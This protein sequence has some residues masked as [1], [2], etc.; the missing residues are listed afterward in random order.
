QLVLDMALNSPGRIMN[1]LRT[2]GEMGY[3]I[4]NYEKLDTDTA[5]FSFIQSN[6][7]D[8]FGAKFIKKYL[9]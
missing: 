4:M 3:R 6:C 8:H 7:T 9:V 2:F 5:R 1:D